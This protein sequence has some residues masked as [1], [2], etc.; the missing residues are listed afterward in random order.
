M[1][2]VLTD[3]LWAAL[4]PLVTQARRTRQ[5]AKPKLPDR[6]VFEA[7]LD[8]ARTGIPSRD[9]PAEFGAW[10]AVY[11]RFR[12]WVASG[13]LRTRFELPTA[14][15]RF[16]GLRRVFVDSTVVRGRQHAAG[17]RRKK[18]RSGPTGRQKPRPSA[19]ATR[20]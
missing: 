16:D 20:A 6:D 5:G 17:A 14:D 8:L 7:L 11:D 18:K 19:A 13:S 10:E 1:R 4:R 15:P 9:L 2:Y 12:R 3:D